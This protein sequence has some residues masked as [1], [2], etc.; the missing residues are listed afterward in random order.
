MATMDPVAVFLA[1][2]IV[3]VAIKIMAD[4]WIAVYPDTVESS[5]KKVSLLTFVWY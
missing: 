1:L 5:V 3:S 4:V 2:Q